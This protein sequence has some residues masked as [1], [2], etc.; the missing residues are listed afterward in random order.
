MVEDGVIRL[1]LQL[2]F[3]TGTPYFSRQGSNLDVVSP[4]PFTPRLAA[5]ITRVSARGRTFIPCLYSKAG[6]SVQQ[7]TPGGTTLPGFV[8]ME[9]GWCTVN[10][11]WFWHSKFSF[12]STCSPPPWRHCFSSLILSVPWFDSHLYYCDFVFISASSLF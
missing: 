3:S 9:G 11:V 2:S 4:P 12:G 5:V 10:D 6:A 8:S 7:G 1:A